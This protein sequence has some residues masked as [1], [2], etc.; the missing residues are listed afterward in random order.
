MIGK[1]LLTLAAIALIWFAFRYVSQRA[2][3]KGR[4]AERRDLAALLRGGRKPEPKA[5][6]IDDTQQCRVCGAYVVVGRAARC[7]RPDCPL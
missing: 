2:E 1:I 5:D 4:H 6:P 3:L 7:G